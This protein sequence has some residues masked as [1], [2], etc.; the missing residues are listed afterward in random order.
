VPIPPAVR[1]V[2]AAIVFLTRVP[3]GGFPYSSEDWRWS[4]AHFPVAGLLVG[5]CSAAAWRASFAAGPWVASALAVAASMMVTG[6]FH[7]DG[8]ADTADALGGAYDREKLFII[9]KDSR[10]GS[11]GSAALTIVL[12]LR[13]A[14]LARL[15]ALAGVALIVTSCMARVPPI[16]L[17]RAMPYVTMDA[18]AKSRS[19]TRAG[20]GQT[21]V[22]SSWGAIAAVVGVQVLALPW[23][24]VVGGAAGCGVVALVCGYRFHVRAGGLTGDFL[25]ATEQLCECALLLALACAVR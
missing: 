15:G 13:V 12:I 4:S 20:W 1:G 11:F 5:V 17:M 18:Q 8:L 22:A 21:L 6:A 24:A 16:W 14:L 9:L 3:V 25:G 2:R 19:V 10:I 7:E 23:R